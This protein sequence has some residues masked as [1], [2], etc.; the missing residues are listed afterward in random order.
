MSKILR[1]LLLIQYRFVLRFVDFV[2][3]QNVD[4][5]NFF[6]DKKIIKP[7]KAV[8]TNGSGIDLQE[9]PKPTSI[10]IAKSKACL[11]SELGLNL[12]KKTV[13]LYPARGVREKG[14]FEFYQAAK[15]INEIEPGRYV[16]VH[17]GLVDSASSSQI[18]KN[19]IDDYAANCGVFYMGFKDDIKS[20]MQASDIVA[21]PSYREGTPRSLI[22][23]LALGKVIVTTDAPGCR[24]TVV[25]GWNGYLCKIQDFK[26]LASSILAVNKTLLDASYSRSRKLCETKYDANFLADLTVEKYLGSHSND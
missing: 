19:G 7:S 25:D 9:F 23:A 15:L 3:F 22:E 10:E 11:E 6:I 17:L 2:Y 18:S 26:S 4:D 12:S 21:L 5:M 16:F 13:V 1:V 8:L 14:F 20:Y 24:E